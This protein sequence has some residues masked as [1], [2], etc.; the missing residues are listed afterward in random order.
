MA[1]AASFEGDVVVR[2]KLKASGWDLPASTLGDRE[3]D[4]A[5][6]LTVD[7]Q[8]H[9]FLPLYAQAG[10]AADATAV[11]HVAKGAG[12]V[13]GFDAGAAVA[14][15]TTATVTFDLKKNGATVLTGVTTLNNTHANY[16]EVVGA[17]DAALVGYAPGDV[18]EVVVNETT[19]GGT[20]ASR[21]Y[22]RPIFREAY[23]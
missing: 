18:F 6:P 8:V 14:P 9:L 23:S 7:K 22:A 5:D 12:T 4:S 16:E 15:L 1:T 19:A 20:Q 11:V 3:F 2:G 17:L 13:I 21:P 10:V